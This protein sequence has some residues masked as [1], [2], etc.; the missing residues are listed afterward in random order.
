MNQ[1]ANALLCKALSCCAFSVALFGVGAVTFFGYS[2]SAHRLNLITSDIEWRAEGQTLDVSHQ[3]HLEDALTLLANLG[4]RDGVL[5]L[6]ASAKLLNYVEQ[7]FALSSR[8]G[9]LALEPYGAHMQGDSLFVYQRVALSQPPEAL[10]VKNRL[11]HDVEPAMRNQVNW[12]VGELVR[13]YSGHRD[14]PVAWLV[15]AGASGPEN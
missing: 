5:D 1:Q 6:E 11:M 3:L 13:S 4:V 15:L 2:A 14:V 12:R 10:E 8:L 9:T 7:H